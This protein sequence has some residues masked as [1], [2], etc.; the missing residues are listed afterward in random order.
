MKPIILEGKD[1]FPL[2][3]V[4]LFNWVISGVLTLIV[5][6][7]F[8]FFIAKSV[9]VGCLVANISFLFLK[10]DLVDFLQGKLLLSGKVDKAKR[11]FYLKYYIRL[12]I[13]AVVLY[14]LVSRHIIHP[15]G[16]LVGLSVV[17]LSIGITLA[18]V[19]KKFYL[20]TKEE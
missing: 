17:V 16:L 2:H 13:I 3:R 7:K 5:A 15:L 19:V 10:K 11:I 1:E 9:F 18:S 14:V 4:E 12:T 6:L 20:N 8:P